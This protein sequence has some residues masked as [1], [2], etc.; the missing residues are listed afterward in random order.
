MAGV[1]GMAG[2]AGMAGEPDVGTALSWWPA[3]RGV[4]TPIGW[5]DHLFRFNVVYNG[6]V[7]AEP[8]PS[9][10]R[11]QHAEPYRG[12]DF[13]LTFA[14]YDGGD[15]P[16]LPEV[17]TPLYKLDGGVG[18]QGWV[19]ASATPILWTQWPVQD[20]LVIRQEVFAHVPGAPD[21]E[22]GTE[23]ISAWI[24]LSVAHVDEVAHPTASPS[25]SDCRRSGSR[26][27]CRT[28]STTA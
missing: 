9:L 20:G 26:T 21:V 15:L 27:G 22:T 4:W 14:V 3:Q 11:R 18:I 17:P 19:E 12:Q 5:K 10:M 23:P 7:L 1:A 6:I 24:R 28:V 16:A 25:A 13:Q 2:L 8:C